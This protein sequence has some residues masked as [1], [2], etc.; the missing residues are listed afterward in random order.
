MSQLKKKGMM[1]KMWA[2][3]TRQKD[4]SFNRDIPFKTITFKSEP[5]DA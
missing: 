4:D 1:S 3:V 5:I 2:T